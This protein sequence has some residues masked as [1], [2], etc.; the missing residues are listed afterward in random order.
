LTS[1]TSFG[2]VEGPPRAEA[3]PI[4]V[5]TSKTVPALARTNDRRRRFSIVAPRE[6][7]FG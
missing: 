6:S 7:K 2:E 1:L 3:E 4:A 5:S